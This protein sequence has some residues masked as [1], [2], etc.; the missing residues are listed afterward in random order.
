MEYSN[1][2]IPEGINTSEE[3]P[4]KEFFILTSGL[5]LVVVLVVSLVVYLVD[6]FADRI[7][8]EWEKNIPVN[9]LLDDKAND[10]QPLYLQN[11]SKRIVNTMS[12]PDGMDITVHYINDDT[13]NAFATL[14]GHIVLFR[15]LLEKLK[16]EDEL[17]MIISHEVA[18]IENRHPIHSAS[19]A[20]I[21]GLI[22]SAITSSE[23]I[24]S[25]LVGSSSMLTMMSFSREYEY[26]SDAKA[27]KT[28]I[29]LYGHAEGA[30]G[31]FNIFKRE[32]EQSQPVE[33]LN[34]H[35]L[36]TNRI[37][38]A[39]SIASQLRDNNTTDNVHHGMTPL[40]KEFINWL[41]YEAS[42]DK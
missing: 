32:S 29:S 14:G 34:T 28:L 40:P 27:V 16:Y 6:I 8:F 13:V 36:T 39:E 15:G 26:E 21:V 42:S 19:Q 9:M 33:F 4:L 5:V 37:L 18:H 23:D 20:L 10:D 17:A 12:L 22:L 24:V 25:G 41:Q 1:P 38:K 11:V 35:P 30:R 3:S 2:K 7:P 31:L